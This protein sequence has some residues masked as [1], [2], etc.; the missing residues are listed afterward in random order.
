MLNPFAH[1][2]LMISTRVSIIVK[3]VRIY[4]KLDSSYRLIYI[5][6][7]T[8]FDIYV[9]EGKVK[10]RERRRRSNSL[11]SWKKERLLECLIYLF[12]C[13]ISRTPKLIFLCDL[14]DSGNSV[15]VYIW[16]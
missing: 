7:F 16:W 12:I 2:Q 5:V 6:Q 11:V 13:Y 8:H 14:C 9:E 4:V 10:E 1:P 3:G 15:G